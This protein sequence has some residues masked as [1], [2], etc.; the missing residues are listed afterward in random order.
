MLTIS[1]LF[2]VLGLVVRY[3]IVNVSKGRILRVLTLITFGLLFSIIEAW[4]MCCIPYRVAMWL[5]YLG[6]NASE[7]LIIR[8]IWGSSAQVKFDLLTIPFTFFGLVFFQLILERIVLPQL[9]H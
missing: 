8:K 4:L 2:T 5:F 9:F 7:F 6:M 3:T 1:T